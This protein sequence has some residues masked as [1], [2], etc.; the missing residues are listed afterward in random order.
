MEQISNLLKSMT[1]I[2]C[3]CKFQISNPHLCAEVSIS[4]SPTKLDPRKCCREISKLLLVTRLQIKNWWDITCFDFLHRFLVHRKVQGGE[5]FQP[6]ILPEV[7]DFWDAGR[8]FTRGNTRY[9]IWN[10]PS[11]RY[12]LYVP[13]TTSCCGGRFHI[14]RMFMYLTLQRTVFYLKNCPWR[15]LYLKVQVE[16]EIENLT[17]GE[18]EP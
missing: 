15:S 17:K 7:L 12:M 4:S 13:D 5:R 1:N 6:R 14:V 2:V 3:A 18:Q 8:A 9:H 16:F 11:Y 10:A